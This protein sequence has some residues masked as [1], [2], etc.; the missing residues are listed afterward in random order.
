MCLGLSGRYWA[1]ILP[2]GT[3]LHGG[4]DDWE[5]G[6]GLLD[7]LPEEWQHEDEEKRAE[8]GFRDLADVEEVAADREKSDCDGDKADHSQ[9]NFGHLGIEFDSSGQGFVGADQV[10]KFLD[11]FLLL[12]TEDRLVLSVFDLEREDS[13]LIWGASI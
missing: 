2:A 12:Q 8:E 13:G 6:D 1:L 7:P 5:H 11:D 4:S 3:L 10:S 9:T